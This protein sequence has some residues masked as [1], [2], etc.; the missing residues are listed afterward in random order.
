MNRTITIPSDLIDRKAESN[1]KIYLG[2]FMDEI[3]SNCV[4]IKTAT[5]CGG[6]T[7]VLKDNVPSIIAMPFVSTVIS[8]IEGHPEYLGVYSDVSVDD[9][10]AYLR[11]SKCHKIVTTYDGLEKVINSLKS[12]GVDPY[13]Y[14]LLVDELHLL[15]NMY[16]L[17][18]D[19]VRY[20]LSESR[21]FST[22]TFMTATPMEHKYFFDEIK[23][24][25]VVTVDFPSSGMGVDLVKV[26]FLKSEVAKIVTD[27][28][29]DRMLGNAHFFVN[30][31]SFIRDIIKACNLT[32]DNTRA[33]C[34]V[35]NKSNSEKLGNFPISS[36]NSGV[37]KI[38]FYTSTAF[39]GC[40]IFDEDA[41]MYIVSDGANKYSMVDVSTTYIQILGR[42]RDCKVRR[43]THL[44]T[45][46]R[47]NGVSAAEF[48]YM[49]TKNIEESEAYLSLFN[50]V[51]EK[52]RAA[53]LKFASTEYL[54]NQYLYY[55]ELTNTVVFDKNLLNLEMVNYKCTNLDY[56]CVANVKAR[57]L[58]KGVMVEE[59]QCT[60]TDELKMGSTEKV[61]F[62]DL[63]DEYAVLMNPD[64]MD[65]IQCR[66][67]RMELIAAKNPTVISAYH[68]LGVDKVYELKYSVT[69]I[70]RE[71]IK[72]SRASVGSKVVM[73]LKFSVGERILIETVKRKLEEA[74]E[75]LNLNYDLKIGDYYD[76]KQSKMKSD[77]KFVSCIQ[78]VRQKAVF[79][80]STK[81]LDSVMASK[82]GKER[83]ADNINM[84]DGME[85]IAVEN[86]KKR[87]NKDRFYTMKEM[88][89][90]ALENKM[91]VESIADM[92]SMDKRVS[93]I[94]GKRVKGYK[95]VD[96]LT[97]QLTLPSK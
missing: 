86:I 22:K 36:I 19:V 61:S 41:R 31:V 34:S 24:L 39:E 16:K 26:N 44:F 40:D 66:K 3:P 96:K 18:R 91:T 90:I 51:D 28:I 47:Y 23:D 7:L 72:K 59:Y 57:L 94:A 42:I 33:I 8:K 92:F 82:L 70:K 9:I 81:E 27:F 63:F 62:K 12:I 88:E 54:N 10:V 79:S 74:K 83:R 15:L 65:D 35:N 75:T 76:V 52:S 71:L 78:I 56:L 5:G 48:E 49:T 58:K 11:K 21:N 93:V 13:K 4:F 25:D 73:L 87:I 64:C 55:D 84:L 1:E 97:A 37:K 53:M 2:D 67:E 20:I 32:V 85:I 14:R 17:R 95:R 43:A 60:V 29:K 45:T 50:S 46:T 30:S 68:K 80:S 6:T 38:N 69:R 89:S 77:G